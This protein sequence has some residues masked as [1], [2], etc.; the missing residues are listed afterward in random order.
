MQGCIKRM[1]CRGA[2]AGVVATGQRGAGR[3][4]RRIKV[5]QKHV[6]VLPLT[7]A[8]TGHKLMA[9]PSPLPTPEPPATDC[10]SR[11]Q[12]R[13]S[14]LSRQVDRHGAQGSFCLSQHVAAV[15]TVIEK[16]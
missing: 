9:P 10:D 15:T 5:D 7:M 8:P 14:D 16:A 12:T 3:S 1:L 6:F 11:G 4:L 2:S 13:C